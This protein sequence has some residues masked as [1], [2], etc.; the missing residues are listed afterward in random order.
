MNGVLRERPTTF[1]GSGGPNGRY[2]QE[3][4]SRKVQVTKALEA[5]LAAVVIP[6]FNQAHFL[7]ECLES[8]LAQTYQSWEAIVIDDASP[9][10]DSIASITRSMNDERIRLVHHDV[11]RGLAAAR[12]TGARCSSS[13]YIVFVDADDKLDPNYL[14]LLV[15]VLQDNEDLDCVFADLQLFGLYNNTVKTTLPEPGA[16]LRGQTVGVGGGML[17]K[18]RL[19]DV[20]GGFDESEIMRIGREDWEFYI[21]VFT[22]RAKAAHVD[23]PLYCYRMSSSSM[24]SRCRSNEH[25]VRKYI[26][27]KHRLAFKAAGEGKRMLAT[28]FDKSGAVARK[29]GKQLVALLRAA[30]A[31]WLFPTK[32]RFRIVM[33]S[34]VPQRLVSWMRGLS[35]IDHP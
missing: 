16:I 8:L 17:M 21:R 15:R 26:Y 7:A 33:A 14:K 32:A 6:C 29:N 13:E 11:N 27:Q 28:G 12:N 24:N 3:P 25:L 35:A 5:P 23:E 18:R 2:G 20:V 1:F 22:S 19:L 9:D 10:S 34:M 30:R 31:W 4:D